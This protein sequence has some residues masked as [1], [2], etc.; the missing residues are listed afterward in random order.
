M[1]I[2][3]THEQLEKLRAERKVKKVGNR[4]N[5]T[6]VLSKESRHRAL[7]EFEETTPVKAKEENVEIDNHVKMSDVYMRTGKYEPKT[8]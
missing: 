2:S 7:K 6:T 3:M 5:R 4:K 1:V 8:K